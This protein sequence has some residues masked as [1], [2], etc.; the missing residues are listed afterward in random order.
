MSYKPPYNLL[1]TGR[2]QDRRRTVLYGMGALAAILVLAGLYIT[3]SWLRAGG[4]GSITLFASDTPTPSS[5][6]TPSLTPTIT[7]TPT[8]TETPTLEPTPTA[9]APF[10]YTVQLG[11][12]LSGIAE[13]FEV[14]FIII[15]AMNGM[16]NESVLF[17]G[18]ELV[19]PDPNT[20]LPDPTALPAGLPPRFEIQYLV[21]PGDTLASIAE[22]FL[23]TEAGIVT[24]NDLENANEI[25]VGQLLFVPIRLITA[26]PGP[27]PTATIPNAPTTATASNTPS[28]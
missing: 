28:P 13:R 16:S 27:S 8:P 5:T 2:K 15:M 21:L 24:A 25:F 9:S 26:T 12:T 19:I 18:Q 3:T 20:G 17:V 4:L 23:S 7:E 22:L 6:L 11:D 14:E 1:K 10:L